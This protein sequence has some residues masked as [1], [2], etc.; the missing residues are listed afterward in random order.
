MLTSGIRDY[1]KD[2]GWDDAFV[3]TPKFSGE[4]G[5]ADAQFR[6]G[7]S[8]LDVSCSSSRVVAGERSEPFMAPVS[9]T[10]Q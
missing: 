8:R 5:S 10:A 7:R 1:A 2:K 9:C 6:F 4:R 3:G